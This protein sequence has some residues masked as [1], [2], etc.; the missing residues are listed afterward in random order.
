MALD[1]A[2]Y[3]DNPVLVRVHRGERVESQHRGAWV[4]VDTSGAVLDGA[5]AFE[6]PVFA[7]SSIKCLQALP[8]LETGAAERFGYSDAELALALASHNG[9]ACHTEG[10]A[11]LLERLGLGVEH[12]RCGPQPP[13]DPEARAELIR[14]DAEPSALHSNCSGKHAGFLALALHL[15]VAVERYLERDSEVQVL[16]RAAVSE[17]SGVPDRE[18]YTAVDGCSA[19][20]FQLPLVALATAFARVSTPDG[21]E[22]VRRAACE[23]MLAA[24]RAHPRL[25]AGRHRRI[26]TDLAALPGGSLFP[27]IGAEAVYV[28]GIRGRD[29]ALAIKVDD[30][31]YRGLHAMLVELLSRMGFLSH[32]DVEALAAWREGP[33]RNWAGLEVGSV[34]VVA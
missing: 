23:Q 14:G 20:T 21:L 7:R 13:A 28:V 6:W 27:K 17:L 1:R 9:E 29:R 33:E 5:G 22:P 4:L 25:I 12:L 10:V 32:T 34:V 31:S 24:V 15:G 8:L 30:G 18:L 16:V 19:P 3:P 26:C 11:R 2:T